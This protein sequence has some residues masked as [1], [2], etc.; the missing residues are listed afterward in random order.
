[1]GGAIFAPKNQT[2]I[3]RMP[4]TIVNVE[5]YPGPGKDLYLPHLGQHLFWLLEEENEKLG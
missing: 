4:H 5:L 3:F 2:G 1:L